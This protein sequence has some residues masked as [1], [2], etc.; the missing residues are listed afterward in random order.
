MFI[1]Y[2]VAFGL[3]VGFLMGGSG[4]RLASLRIRWP[5]PIALGMAGQLV[6]F[7]EPVA[8]RVGELGP[9]LYVTTT[10]MVLVGIVRNLWIPGLW[11]VFVGA[12]GNLAALLA[13]GG[14]MPASQAALQAA[15]RTTPI[16]YSNSSSAADPALWPLTDILALPSWMPLANVFSPGDLM[17]GIGIALVIVRAMRPGSRSVTQEV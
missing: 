14:Y 16:V 6:L 10:L 5:A 8:H 7:S 12:A 9:A 3:L 11:L 13:N 2:A 15:G 4:E 17:I 1:L